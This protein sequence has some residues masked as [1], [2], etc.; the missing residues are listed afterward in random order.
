M[1]GNFHDVLSSEVSADFYQKLTFSTRSFRKKLY[2]SLD[3]DQA[4]HFV[5]PKTLEKLRYFI[6]GLINSDG[7]TALTPDVK[8][9][10]SL[11]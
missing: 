5:E 11:L 4:Q 3:Q 8:K 1:L 9:K 7:W 6:S 10:I 2:N